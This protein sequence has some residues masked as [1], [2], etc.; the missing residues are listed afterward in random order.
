M[1]EETRD[2]HTEP[3]QKTSDTERNNMNTD[4]QNTLDNINLNMAKMATILEK[5]CHTP[6]AGESSQKQRSV[7]HNI[8][9]TGERSVTH[10][11]SSGLTGTKRASQDS[12]SS[13]PESPKNKRLRYRE[14]SDKEDSVRVY[15]SDSWDEDEDVRQLTGPHT[16][17]RENES[18]AVMLDELTRAFD[19]DEVP[20]E[21]I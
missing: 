9:L 1:D 2:D 10:D 7:T 4:V 12:D 21:K 11:E 19:D 3:A 13:E 14:R 20:G 15:T 18:H 8:S 17:E 5:F 6:T 16:K